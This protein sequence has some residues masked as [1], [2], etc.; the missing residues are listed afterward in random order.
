MLCKD[1]EEQRFCQVQGPLLQ[2]LIHT[3]RVGC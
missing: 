1:Q 2:V 3:L